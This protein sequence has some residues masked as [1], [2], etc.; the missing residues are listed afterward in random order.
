M[1]GSPV[2]TTNTTAATHIHCGADSGI[3]AEPYSASS[4]RVSAVVSG[5]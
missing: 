3:S 4:R 5:D 1:T 2:S